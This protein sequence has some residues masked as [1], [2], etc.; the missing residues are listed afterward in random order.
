[1]VI[2]LGTVGYIYTRIL[3]QLSSQIL[4]TRTDEDKDTSTFF[5]KASPA[6]RAIVSLPFP[7]HAYKRGDCLLAGLS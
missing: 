3:K 7:N 1:V 5:C 6:S 2:K 4:F